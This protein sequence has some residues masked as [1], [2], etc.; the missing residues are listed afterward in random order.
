MSS[1][2]VLIL[3]P[4]REVADQTYQALCDIGKYFKGTFIASAL[5]LFHYCLV[6]YNERIGQGS[7]CSASSEA[8]R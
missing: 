4:T 6:L 1:P 8:S 3:E 2:Q 7:W 5:F